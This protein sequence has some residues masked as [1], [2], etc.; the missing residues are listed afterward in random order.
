ME[1]AGGK[2]S[3]YQKRQKMIETAVKSSL[4]AEKKLDQ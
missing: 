1:R 3:L 4:Y 2:N